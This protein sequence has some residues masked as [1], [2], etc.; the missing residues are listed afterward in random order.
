M[1]GG[2]SNDRITSAS[3]EEQARPTEGEWSGGRVQGWG[4]LEFREGG[5]SE[6]RGGRR[7]G[8]G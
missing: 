2:G 7:Q 6:L 3:V 5:E 4:R 1:L 8:G